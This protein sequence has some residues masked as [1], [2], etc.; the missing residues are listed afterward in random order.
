MSN[1][2]EPLYNTSVV[3]ITI[4]F[5]II[6]IIQIYHKSNIISWTCH[7]NLSNIKAYQLNIRTTKRQ[8]FL[9][10]FGYTP[11][12][13]NTLDTVFWQKYTIKVHMI[14]YKKLYKT[15]YYIKTFAFTF[16]F[17]D[18]ALPLNTVKSINRI[19]TINSK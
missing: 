11:T 13:Q 6:L 18:N 9:D 16:Y 17:S 12:F 5:H 10:L 7:K 8:F 3:Q 1:K 2:L 4:D 19:R 14:Y 15:K